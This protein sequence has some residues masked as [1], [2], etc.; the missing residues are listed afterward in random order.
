MRVRF[1]S[2]ARD[3]GLPARHVRDLYRTKLNK[4]LFYLIAAYRDSG[5]FTGLRYA[6][7]FYPVP[8][9]FELLVAGLVDDEALALREQGDAR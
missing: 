2:H 3:R 7:P 8:D 6:G 9:R 5:G 1:G 4:V